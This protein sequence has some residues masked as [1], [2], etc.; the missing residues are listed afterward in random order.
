MEENAVRKIPGKNVC[1]YV[2]IRMFKEIYTKL[3]ALIVSQVVS[4]TFFNVCLLVFSLFV[5]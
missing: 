5:H 1:V 4:L 2:D 3:L